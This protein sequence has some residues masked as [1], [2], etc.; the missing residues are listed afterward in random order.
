MSPLG[1]FALIFLA[2]LFLYAVGQATGRS[3][4]NGAFT[5]QQAEPIAA[6]CPAPLKPGDSGE[7]VIK[8]QRALHQAGHAIDIDGDYGDRT[9]QAVAT[10]QKQHKLPAKVFVDDALWRALGEC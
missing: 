6:A 8:L 7:A 5:S 3:G 2:A 9:R 4:G 1:V 10:A